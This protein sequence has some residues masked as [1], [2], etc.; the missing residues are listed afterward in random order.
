MLPCWV[1]YG[2][3]VNNCYDLG[4]RSQG[5]ATGEWSIVI[6]G[7]YKPLVACDALPCF[8]SKNVVFVELIHFHVFFGKF[9]FIVK[10]KKKKK[11]RFIYYHITSSC[12]F[13]ISLN[14]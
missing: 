6:C 7:I 4:L 5:W 9:L 10:L 12:L 8:G 11:K 3:D 2:Y 14:A 1:I 13:N